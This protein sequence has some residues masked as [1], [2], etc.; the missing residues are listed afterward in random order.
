[1]LSVLSPGIS[2]V[3]PICVLKFSGV[4]TILKRLDLVQA[5]ILGLL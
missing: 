5:Q 1:M 3:L 4:T 2:L